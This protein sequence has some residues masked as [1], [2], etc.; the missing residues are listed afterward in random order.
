MAMKLWLILFAAIVFVQAYARADVV[1]TT[2]FNVIESKKTETL[3]VLSG[4]DGRVYK[5]KKTSEGLKYLKAL[6]GKVVTLSYTTR[7]EE[8]HI[9][10]IRTVAPGEVDT[11][12][13]DLNHFQYNQLREFAPTE[14]QSMEE[15]NNLFTTLLNDGDRS[16]SQCFKRAH[17]WS[18]DMW[19]KLNI[20]SQ[21]MFIFYTQRYVQ[22]E[23]FKW[24]F[25]V[26]PSVV[27]NGVDMVM[28]G[29]FMEKPMTVR[30]WQNFFMKS[31]KI[32]CPMIENYNQYADNQWQ[33]LCYTLKVPMYYLS[34][35]DI[36]NRDNKNIQKDHWVLEELQD[37]RRAFK[38]Y[39]DVYEGLD[40]GKPT[41][42]Y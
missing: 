8:S 35:L 9:D 1:V 12:T 38:N 42:T 28:D 13:M 5:T 14:L 30:A 10:Q 17:M 19:S 40:T 21:K 27:V 26:A 6:K 18:F 37:A 39:L 31:E 33:K 29:T 34:P 3:L 7:G 23:D 36:E 2:V 11:R 4:V 24:W 15:A 20:N 16:R 25:H 41:I 32:R 22:L